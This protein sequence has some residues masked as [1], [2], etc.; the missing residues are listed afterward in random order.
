MT[1]LLPEHLLFG[2]VR[3]GF[4]PMSACFA[5]DRAW[6]SFTCELLACSC[7]LLD[8]AE[9]VHPGVGAMRLCKPCEGRVLQSRSPGALLG[10]GVV[11][12]IG[13]DTQSLQQQIPATTARRAG[14]R[15]SQRWTPAQA[16]AGACRGRNLFRRTAQLCRASPQ[17]SVPDLKA[18][19]PVQILL[20]A[21]TR[22][23]RLRGTAACHAWD[24]RYW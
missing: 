10:T 4:V 15:A 16:L 14:S 23:S 12:C 20:R 6:L 13:F 3:R 22:S 2:P 8:P 18:V 11:P 24:C 17:D 1:S 21:V 5:P 9:P 19:L 7:R